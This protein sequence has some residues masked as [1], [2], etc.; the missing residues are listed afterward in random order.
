MHSAN[1][2]D[3]QRG[4][5]FDRRQFGVY[6]GL[7]EMFSEQAESIPLRQLDDAPNTLGASMEK[8]WSRWIPGVLS[9]SQLKD[10]A[11]NGYITDVTAKS[12]DPSAID[13]HVAQ[14]C[15]RLKRGTVKPSGGEFFEN[16]LKAD[17][18]EPMKSDSDGIWTLNRKETYL[19]P[20]KESLKGLR[21]TPIWGHATAKSSI[22]RVD[23]LARLIIDGMSYYERF[24]PLVLSD[25][26]RM[27]LE[28]TPITF[29]VRVR[30][31]DSL[32]QLR[33]FYGDPLDCELRGPGICS[34]CLGRDVFNLTVDLTPV[35]VFDQ[36]GC[37]YR[38]APV[39][40]DEPVPLWKDKGKEKGNTDPH[41]WWELVRKDKSERLRIEVDRFYILRSVERLSVPPGIA[42][43]ARAIDEEIGEMRIHYAGFAHPYFGWER[44][45]MKKGTPLI[46]EVRG[47]SV[48][49]S[50]RHGEILARLQF[51]RMS[52]DPEKEP[53]SYNQQELNLSNYFADWTSSPR[54]S[55]A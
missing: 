49:V 21:N 51:F 15:Y 22:G 8:L 40:S 14:E 20:L 33:F 38:A 25:G 42:V 37:G 12:F 1:E 16:L 24:D 18:A 39:D 48:P 32:N 4:D 23:V 19:F 46:F 9:N 29:R 5:T 45:D 10:L 34:T 50:L 31:G 52:T 2:E 26:G 43:Y 17:L 11:D 13:L 6:S 47:H 41:N 44:P 3:T 35:D 7:M 55:N 28:V 53:P 54:I 36:S 27:F 30:P